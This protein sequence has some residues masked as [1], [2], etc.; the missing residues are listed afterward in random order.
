M[1]GVI[2]AMLMDVVACAKP[3]R[4]PRSGGSDRYPWVGGLYPTW[5]EPTIQIESQGL[6]AARV[7]FM[8]P[9]STRELAR[10]RPLPGMM[11]LFRTLINHRHGNAHPTCLTPDNE[12]MVQLGERW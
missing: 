5:L 12:M 6:P 9:R 2:A 7:R 1:R 8:S 3:I 11:A 10:A 4:D